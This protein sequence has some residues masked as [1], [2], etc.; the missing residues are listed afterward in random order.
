[1]LIE[2]CFCNQCVY[3]LHQLN[4]DTLLNGDRDGN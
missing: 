4:L 2:D 3:I 1:M